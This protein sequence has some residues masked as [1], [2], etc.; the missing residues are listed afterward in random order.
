MTD[1]ELYERA[2]AVG[3]RAYAPYS[4]FRVGAAVLLRSGGVVTGVNVENA[5]YPLGMCAERSALARAV[6]E[7]A[8]PGEIETVAVTASPCGGC[9]QW[10]LELR[11]GR[12][13]FARG[14]E[15]LV[16]TPEELLPD[17]FELA[18]ERA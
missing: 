14:G 16:R 4:R 12:V 2:V 17:S 11:V 5:S 18:P 8:R 6:A 9:R 7:G 15:L 13:V 10:L 1:R 3:G